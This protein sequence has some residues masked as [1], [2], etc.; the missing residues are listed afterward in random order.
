MFCG[1]TWKCPIDGNT[2]SLFC[3]FCFRTGLCRECLFSCLGG[4]N[5]EAWRII[6]QPGDRPFW[7]K[8]KI[9]PFPTCGPR[10]SG[11][12]QNISKCLDVYTITSVNW[13]NDMFRKYTT[14]MENDCICEFI[15]GDSEFMM[16]FKNGVFCSESLG[17][18]D[19]VWC[20]FDRASLIP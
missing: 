3:I 11:R 1:L 5:S 8:H 9:Q 10:I 17:N 14:S 2:V 4:F 19:V 20:L 13:L 18:T 15:C 7:R 6:L 16:I 12:P